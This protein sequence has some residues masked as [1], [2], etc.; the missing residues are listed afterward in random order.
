MIINTL[1]GAKKNRDITGRGMED[2]FRKPDT[3][4]RDEKFTELTRRR[5]GGLRE[6]EHAAAGSAARAPSETGESH[7]AH[8]K[9]YFI[10]N[11]RDEHVS[12]Q[13]QEAH[14]TQS[15]INT[16]KITPDSTS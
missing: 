6:R 5:R 4:H 12:P 1:K 2:N 15:K 14:R 16:K 7:Q 10:Y 9:K 13:I 11:K 8:Q 3:T